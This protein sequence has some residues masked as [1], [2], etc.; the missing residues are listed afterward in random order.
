MKI[1]ELKLRIPLDTLIWG[2]NFVAVRMIFKRTKHEFDL[3]RAR[4]RERKVT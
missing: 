1:R 4:E 2:I 3:F